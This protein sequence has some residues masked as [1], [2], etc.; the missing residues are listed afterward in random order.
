M[1]RIKTEIMSWLMGVID[2]NSWEKYNDLHIDEVDNVFKNKSNWVGGGLDC[3]IQAVSI[4][5]ELNIPYTIELAFSLKS[6]KKIANHIIT[7]INFLKKELDHSPPSLY[8]FHNDWKGLSELKQ[9]G[10]KLSNF[11]DNDE[12]VGSFYYYQ[13]FNERDS[14]VR[15]VLFCI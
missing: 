15:R 7:D 12:I 4:I 3:Y 2:D 13:V 5:K 1:E 14:E 11:T 9:K 10:I 8:V 6:K